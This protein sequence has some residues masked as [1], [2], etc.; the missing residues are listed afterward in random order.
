MQCA[1]AR[2][3]FAVGGRSTTADN[4]LHFGWQVAA[5]T[6]QF[7][8]QMLVV[9]WVNNAECHG[10]GVGVELTIR[11]GALRLHCG[12]ALFPYANDVHAQTRSAGDA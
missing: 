9:A 3:S 7:F 4:D 6:F 8:R 5:Q 1:D 10:A 11:A 12:V 2:H